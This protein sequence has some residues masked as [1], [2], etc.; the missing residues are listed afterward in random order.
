MSGDGITTFWE[1]L[2]G[3]ALF[4]A[5]RRRAVAELAAAFPD[6][7]AAERTALAR[8]SAALQARLAGEQFAT[9][10][11]VRLCRDLALDGADSLQQ[12]R[13]MNLANAAVFSAPFGA[14][15]LA[16]RAVGLY[17]DN[18]ERRVCRLPTGGG[19]A[20]FAFLGRTERC[21]TDWLPRS[22]EWLFPVFATLE[23][24][25]RT[26]VVFE[27]PLPV[28][29]DGEGATR[30]ALAAIERAVRARPEAWAWGARQGD[31]AE[32]QASAPG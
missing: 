22:T 3:E 12:L 5:R 11:A 24:Q 23:P 2:R 15:A 4:R 26:R 14:P 17:G 20:R 29:G 9:R 30:E 18:A 10:D 13:S 32:P 1:R 21:A 25:R 16:E 6:L 28:A 19:A 8:R 27:A 7:T 31:S